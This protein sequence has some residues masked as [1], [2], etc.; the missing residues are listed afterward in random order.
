MDLVLHIGA[1][2][3][4][5]TLV[6]Q[7]VA[8]SVDAQPKCGVAIWPPRRLRDMPGFQS[9]VSRLDRDAEPIS[10]EAAIALDGLASDITRQMAQEQ[11]RG[12]TRLILSEENFMGGMRNNFNT[13]TFYPDVAR[14]LASFDSLLPTS[15]KIVALGVRDY[16]AVW[17]S[18]Y[19][20]QA[21]VGKEPPEAQSIHDVL[22]D[23]RRGWPEVIAAIQEV[24]PDTEIL[25][26]RQEDLAQG[27]AA[28]C[29]ALT[30]LEAGQISVPGEQVNAR[31][32]TAQPPLFTQ[33]EAKH[34]SQ[35]Y[36]RHIRR[37]KEQP[38]LRWVAV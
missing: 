19:Y 16:G 27:A 7:A 36:T 14:R 20:Y 37:L 23:S 30:G 8:A 1:H 22:L 11:A 9:T 26:W 34:L 17:T 4:G 29:A 6:A 32:K 24:W 25:L 18:A 13:G 5:S 15:P 33:A 12:I 2:R 28:V 35:R 3:T 21:Q 31:R 10:K 38:G